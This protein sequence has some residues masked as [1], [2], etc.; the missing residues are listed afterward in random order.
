MNKQNT[1]ITVSVSLLEEILYRE[2]SVLNPQDVSILIE[3]LCDATDTD[4]PDDL[5]RSSDVAVCPEF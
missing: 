1:F 5:L 3:V 4:I 2:T